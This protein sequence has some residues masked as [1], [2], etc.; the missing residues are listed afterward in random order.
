MLRLLAERDRKAQ[1]KRHVEPWCHGWHAVERHSREV[2]EGI[3]TQTKKLDDAI[4]PP[5][6]T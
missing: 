4:E 3:A 5:L 6:A 2:M 1:F